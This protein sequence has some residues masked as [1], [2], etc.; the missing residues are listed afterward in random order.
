[1]DKIV[2]KAI[3]I[4]RS[5]FK[6]ARGTPIQASAEGTASG[7]IEL[8]P[9]YLPGLKDLDGFSHLILLYHFHKAGKGSLIVKPFLEDEEHGVFAV[10]APSRPNSIGLS[11]VCLQRIEG[12]ILYI[13]DLDILDG[14]P[15]LDIKPYVPAFDHRDNVKSGWLENNLDKLSIT[16]DDGRFLKEEE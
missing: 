5:P 12:N 4:I 13:D 2:Y 14:T 7:R 1:M 15:L 3:G 10:R 11:I 9:E 6:E 16:E 8:Y